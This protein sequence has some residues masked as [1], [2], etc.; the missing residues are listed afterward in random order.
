MLERVRDE[1]HRFALAY[2]KKLRHKRDFRSTL[3]D[4]PGVGE[5]IRNKLLIHFGS[6][7][8][9]RE[10]SLEDLRQIPHLRQEVAEAVY[11]FFNQTTK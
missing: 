6:V 8:K 9:V 2:H 7:E 4:V 1:S 3:E 10:A 11:N 5:K